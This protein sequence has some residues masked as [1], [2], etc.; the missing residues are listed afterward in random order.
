MLNTTKVIDNLLSN[1][2]KY[3]N[4]NTQ[5]T[6]TMKQ[7]ANYVEV[8][9]KDQGPGISLENQK[10][11]FGTFPKLNI[12]PTGGEKS[13]GLGLAIVKKILAAHNGSVGIDSA[14]EQGSRFYFRLPL[15]A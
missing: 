11:L 6:I 13:T 14:N 7:D 10:S 5:I 9:V 3:S 2:L 8:S 1:A 4:Q 15:N 12:K